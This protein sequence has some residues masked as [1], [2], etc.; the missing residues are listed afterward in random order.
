[1]IAKQI[2]YINQEVFQKY[3]TVIELKPYSKD[4]WEI[5]VKVEDAGWRIAVLEFGRRSTAKLEKHPRSK[6]SFEPLNGSALLI[7]AESSSPQDFEVFFL[8]TP[9]CL[10]EGIWHQ[11]ISLSE[12]C[13]VKITENLEVACEYY[14]FKEEVTPCLVSLK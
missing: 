11:V 9:V 2:R 14:D 10:N 1:M 8:D 13:T 12:T 7:V 3:G 6:E 4:G 5:V